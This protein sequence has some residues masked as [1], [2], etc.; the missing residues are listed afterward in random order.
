MAVPLL[1]HYPPGWKD[2]ITKQDIFVLSVS[3]VIRKP[4]QTAQLATFGQFFPISFV[5]ESHTPYCVQCGNGDPPNDLNNQS[6]GWECAQLRNLQALRIFLHE[7]LD[8]NLLAIIDDD[9]FINPKIN[10]MLEDMPAIY[11]LRWNILPVWSSKALM[12]DQPTYIGKRST[13]G[14]GYFINKALLEI[15]LQPPL[16]HSPSKPK[17]W[18]WHKQLSWQNNTWVHVEY[19]GSPISVFPPETLVDSC[20]ELQFGGSWCQFHSDWALPDC[21][22]SENPVSV[23][24]FFLKKT[25]QTRQLPRLSANESYNMSTK[26]FIQEAY[27][28]HYMSPTEMHAAYQIIIH[29]K[30]AVIF[31]NIAAVKGYMSISTVSIIIVI[32]I[33]ILLG[34]LFRK[35]EILILSI[36]SILIIFLIRLFL[37]NSVR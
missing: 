11:N 26:Q 12:T 2:G 32:I 30:K 36:L 18:L 15:L 35:M 14:A 10:K 3:S 8:V 4:F 22:R 23:Y 31:N 1:W 24:P 34:T 25:Y 9:T 29:S 5:E 16:K 19:F 28:L 37:L 20:I 7:K 27:T 33:V 13:G 17:S 6:Y 21:F